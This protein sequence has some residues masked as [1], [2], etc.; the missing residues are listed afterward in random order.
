M[1]AG[2]A[3]PEPARP[4]GVFVRKGCSPAT[5]YKWIRRFVAPTGWN[6][7]SRAPRSPAGV[8][9]RTRARIPGGDRDRDRVVA[10]RPTEVLTHLAKSPAA[11]GQRRRNIERVR[12]HQHDVRRLD[13]DVRTGADRDPQIGAG[14]RGS[15]VDTEFW[16]PTG[17]QV[18][19][20]DAWLERPPS[21]PGGA[22]C[23]RRLSVE[24]ATRST[25]PNHAR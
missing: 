10:D 12:T 8:R 9:A 25:L 16:S 15:V 11:D 13:G 4:G 21:P 7:T 6:P 24:F 22:S 17:C 18:Q 20:R 1:V 14:E 19:I 3:D 23:L 5:G 2:R